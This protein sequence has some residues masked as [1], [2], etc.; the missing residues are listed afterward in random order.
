MTADST[1]AKTVVAMEI[2]PSPGLNHIKV[3]RYIPED[4]QHEM[5][6]KFSDELPDS[7]QEL[8]PLLGCLTDSHYS[9]SFLLTCASPSSDSYFLLRSMLIWNA[10]VDFLVLNSNGVIVSLVI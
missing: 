3:L 6:V 5:A 8:F 1:H 10:S 9:R 2:T 4:E 7:E